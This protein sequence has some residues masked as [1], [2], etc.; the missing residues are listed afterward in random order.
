MGP[1]RGGYGGRVAAIHSPRQDGDHKTVAQL[2]DKKV[3]LRN[4]QKTLRIEILGNAAAVSMLN[5]E[6]IFSLH[7]VRSN[8][9]RPLD[10]GSLP[11]NGGS[12]MR[13]AVIYKAVCC[14]NCGL[15]LPVTYFPSLNKWLCRRCANRENISAKTPSSF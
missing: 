6:D 14:E 10:A 3:D 5:P 1:E 2:I 4:P 9:S 15:I 7:K 13:Q 12:S 11:G 8:R